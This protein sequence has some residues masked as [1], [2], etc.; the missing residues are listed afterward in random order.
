MPKKKKP[1]IVK[2]MIQKK[3]KPVFIKVE[4]QKKKKQVIIKIEPSNKKPIVKARK[5]TII[6]TNNKGIKVIPRS[7]EIKNKSEDWLKK[8]KIISSALEYASLAHPL[9]KFGLHYA[10]SQGYGRNRGGGGSLRRTISSYYPSLN[11]TGNGSNWKSRAKTT[12]SK[13]GKYAIPLVMAGVIASRGR[14]HNE[15]PY[16]GDVLRAQYE[17][18]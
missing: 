10:R 18:F 9:A 5:K 2:V 6:R 3:K 12:I 8:T 16:A 4:P 11:N 1:R 13:Y 15:I 14:R 17:Q 7:S